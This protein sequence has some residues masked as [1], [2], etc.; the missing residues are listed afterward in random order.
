VPLIFFLVPLMLETSLAF[1]D[2]WKITFYWIFD[3]DFVPL[4]PLFESCRNKIMLVMNIIFCFAMCFS[5]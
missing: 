5:I 2:A 3:I 4:H 1:I